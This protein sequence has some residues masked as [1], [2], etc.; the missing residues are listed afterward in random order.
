MSLSLWAGAHRG[1]F[2]RAVV[3]PVEAAGRGCGAG[4]GKRGSFRYILLACSLWYTVGEHLGNRGSLVSPEKL[5]EAKQL[6]TVWCES[7]SCVV[8]GL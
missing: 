4:D 8:W 5:T 6:C 1:G 2:A 7:S 3:R